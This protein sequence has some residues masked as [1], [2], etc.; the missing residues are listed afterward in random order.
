MNVTGG[1][2]DMSG[3]VVSGNRAITKTGTSEGVAFAGGA[4]EAEGGGTISDTRITGNFSSIDSPHSAAG[5]SGALGVFGNDS[6]LTVRDSV[7]TGNTAIARSS[8]GSADVQGVGVFN[9]GLI[10]LVNVHGQRQLGEGHRTLGHSAGRRN[11]QRDRRHRAAG[12]AHPRAHHR[13]PQLAGREPRRHGAG[14]R[15]VLDAAGHG[16]P[17]GLADHAERPRSV[18][19]LLIDVKAPRPRGDDLGRGGP[20][21][22]AER[23]SQHLA[24]LR[25][26][27]ERVHQADQR[28][29]GWLDPD[30]GPAAR[31]VSMVS[32]S[33]MMIGTYESNRISPP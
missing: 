16:R 6:L 4:L 29:A 25:R 2:L 3:S 14:R 13:D 24:D 9:D 26:D 10:T 21:L 30:A 28:Q 5:V 1:T 33:T 11:L 15:P 7:I 12:A 31:R 8:T 19:R 18:L 27:R 22:D 20:R 17:A 23:G 32:P